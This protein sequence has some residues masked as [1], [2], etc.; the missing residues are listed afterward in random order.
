MLLGL[1]LDGRSAGGV[2]EGARLAERAG[3]D[4]VLFGQPTGGDDSPV[5]A[6]SLSLAASLMITTKAIGLVASVVDDWAP[7]NVARAL[8]SFDL[9]SGGRCGWVAVR[10]PDA[11]TA[12]SV[13]HLD[14]VLQLLDSWEGEALVLDKAAGVFADRTRVHRIRHSGDFYTVDGPLNAPRSPQGRPVLFQPIATASEDADLVLV[15]FADLGGDRRSFRSAKR[16][17]EVRFDSGVEN[18]AV[19]AER[20]A[21]AYREG[22]CDGF[23]LDAAP[24][25]LVALTG[26]VV[27]ALRARAL[28]D[29]DASDF[30]TRLGLARPANRFAGRV[31]P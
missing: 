27:S 25:D 31:R 21:A 15:D 23:L 2:S 1:R 5:G 16:L 11:E 30:R 22:L 28:P 12:R 13:E 14:V 26:E 20:L 19:F 24:G 9:L 10:A 4:F 8:G 29:F 17:A 6:D 7:F 3:M 18:G